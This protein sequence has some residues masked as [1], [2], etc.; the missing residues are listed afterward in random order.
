MLNILLTIVALVFTLVILVG[1][2]VFFYA[3]GQGV[4]TYLKAKKRKK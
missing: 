2:F 3:V 4:K 1:A